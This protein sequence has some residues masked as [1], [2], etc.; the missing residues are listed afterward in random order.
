MASVY[1]KVKSYGESLGCKCGSIRWRVLANTDF[2]G[3]V[4]AP[5][6]VAALKT[7]GLC[8]IDRRRS[9]TNAAG[10]SDRRLLPSNERIAEINSRSEPAAPARRREDF[11]G[12]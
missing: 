9:V 6:E 3:I 7:G 5:N 12:E 2:V 4:E 11:Y 8:R 1:A 10:L